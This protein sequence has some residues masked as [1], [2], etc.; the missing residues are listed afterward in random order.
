MI[1]MTTTAIKHAL[2]SVSDK[3]ELD[4]LA[5]FLAGRGVTLLSTGGTA[6]YLKRAGLQPIEVSSTTGFPEIL[7]GRVKTLHPKIFGGLLC[8]PRNPA[9]QS[10]LERHSIAP[11]GLVVVN[12]YPFEQT[13]TR[14]G[15]SWADCVENIDIGGVALLRAAA[16]NHARV[17]VL[18]DPADYEPF[19]KEWKELGEISEKTRARLAG[20]AFLHTARYDAL[21]ARAFAK[22][23][24]SRSAATP[25]RVVLALDRKSELRYGENPHQQGAI[26]TE[27]LEGGDITGAKVLQGK[28]VSYNNYFDADAAWR[29]AAD[30]SVLAEKDSKKGLAACAVIKHGIP[31][32]AGL[33]ASVKDAFVRAHASDPVSAFGGVVALSRPPDAAAA[34]EMVKYFLEV[35]AAPS[36]PAEARK[37]FKSK[38]G[39]RLLATGKPRAR[40]TG[41]DAKRVGG[42]WL[43]Q[44]WDAG[45]TGPGRWKIVTKKKPTAAQK[46]ALEFAWTVVKHVRSNAIVVA[47]ERATL[48]IGAGQTSRV[49]AA[50]IALRHA[51]KKARGA[52]L[53]SDG[54]FPFRDSADKAAKAG[55]SAIVQPGGSKRDADVVAACNEHRIAMALTGRRHF[56]H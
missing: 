12:L 42:G 54:F 9:H 17:L 36:F 16:K 35:I 18:C 53:A 44:A 4:T 28:G 39:L 49:T 26:Y 38:A 22:H 21:I 52:V 43:L 20:K 23:T 32:G 11:I 29:L 24:S 40:R 7:G 25:E 1:K 34:R 15:A 45:L 41:W 14:R 30:L 5:S 10:D 8:D 55:L 31:C 50:Y 51:G 46:R 27:P 13:A 47:G 19:T 48:G 56:R 2:L 33:G 6:A 3:S 37:I